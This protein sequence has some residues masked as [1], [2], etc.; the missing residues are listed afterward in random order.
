LRNVHLVPMSWEEEVMLL[1]RELDRAHAA[2]RLEE[3]RNRNLPQLVAIASPEEYDRR[4][5][6][7]VSKYLAFLDRE[8]IL[9]VRD[10]MDPA[11][12]RRIG[13]YAPLET[14]NFFQIAIHFEP[15]TLW[16]HF[17][18]WWD[19]SLMERNPHPSPIRRGPLLYN[20]FDSRAEG[21]AT[22]VEEMMMHAGLYDDN[23][24]AREIV[25]I[26]L[27]QRAARGTHIHTHIPRIA[28]ISCRDL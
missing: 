8:D 12:R 4:A 25:W 27:A 13:S 6:E 9:D 10:Y 15:M 16:T 24:R 18:H 3:H 23:P 14:R 17:Y 19:L 20:V 5:N 28:T 11:L 22:G 7:A 26:L 21:L 2:L 1:K